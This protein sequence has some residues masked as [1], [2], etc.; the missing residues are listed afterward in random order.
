[1]RLLYGWFEG[2]DMKPCPGFAVERVPLHH[3][4][5]VDNTC[6]AD[7]LVIYFA[8]HGELEMAISFEFSDLRIILIQ[9]ESLILVAVDAVARVANAIFQGGV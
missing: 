4:G 7:D 8:G 1:M 5:R 3:I 2:I 9:E 6:Q